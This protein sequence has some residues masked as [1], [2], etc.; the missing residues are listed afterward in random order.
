MFL[1]DLHAQQKV[2]FTQYMF[3]ELILNPA[4]AGNDGALSVTMMDRS[5]WVSVEGAPVTQ[6]FSGHT[7]FSNKKLGAG[8]SFIN[9]KIG[10]HRTQN[11]Q[12]DLAYRLSFSNANFVSFG[13]RTG[14]RIRKSDYASIS[15]NTLDPMLANPDFTY[16]SFIMGAGLYYKSPKF[17]LGISVPDLIPE[18]ISVSDTLAIRWSEAQY[19]IFARYQWT[20]NS[21]IDIAPAV[22]IKY[23]NGLPISYDIN[24]NVIIKKVLTTGVSYRKKESLS[25]LLK[26]KITPQLQ[27][28][29]AYDFGIGKLSGGSGG[30]H[31]AML[32]YIFRY[33]KKNIVSPR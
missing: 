10:V 26:A 16:T 15:G 20:L 11:I 32:N 12:G 17:Q 9:D 21:S 24:A 29:Y 25:F 33:T 3:N 1:C 4:F 7:F 31:E 2:Q 6:T 18:K 23:F 30:S 19:F 27:I 5:Q 13:L 28:G 8:L 14:L 22:L